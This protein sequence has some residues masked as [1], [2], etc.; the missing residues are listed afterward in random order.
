MTTIVDRNETIK[1]YY[2][3]V[4]R[5]AYRMANKMPNHIDVE[6]LIHVGVIGL[7]EAID[8][9]D[10]NQMAS[11]DAYLKIRLQGAMVDELRR[12]DW[13][14]R[15]VR[16][17]VQQLEYARN[18]F[19]KKHQRKPTLAELANEL[20]ITLDS[21]QNMIRYSDIRVVV[22]VEDRFNEDMRVGD[23]IKDKE[24]GPEKIIEADS[25][26]DQLQEVIGT[27]PERERI[28]V[29]LYYFQEYSFKEIAS[30]LKVT[31]SRISQIH[32]QLKKK[33]S[34]RLSKVQ[35]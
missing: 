1:R 24:D 11:F 19:L 32:G 21:L 2:P 20:D 29:E 8:K 18:H 9:Y 26:S 10:A 16:D 15:S 34:M 17:R 5:I 25:S 3:L 30:V 33:L 13:V 23:Y 31:E 12:S 6:D 28:I 35:V 22:S 14:P 7:I 27:L 4:K